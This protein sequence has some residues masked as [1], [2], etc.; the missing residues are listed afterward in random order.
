MKKKRSFLGDPFHFLCSQ[1]TWAWL[2]G[3]DGIGP[4]QYHS[5]GCDELIYTPLLPPGGYEEAKGFQEQQRY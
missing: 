4:L 1:K 5:L 3:D 2:D